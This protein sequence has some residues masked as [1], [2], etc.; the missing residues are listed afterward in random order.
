M[1]KLFAVAAALTLIAVTPLFAQPS[2]DDH[3]RDDH[4]KPA[5]AMS[6]KGPAMSMHGPSMS[7]KG[8]SMSMKGPSMSMKGGPAMHRHPE[9]KKGGRISRDDWGRGA[10]LDY[11]EHHLNKP[12]RG[13]EWR[14]VDGNFILAAAA[15]GL[16]ASL[17]IASH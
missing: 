4:G 1:K 16:I 8:P 14:E 5:P 17:I 2:R 10:R 11:R 15:T 12:P 7:M 9:W 13:Y 6:M 3:G